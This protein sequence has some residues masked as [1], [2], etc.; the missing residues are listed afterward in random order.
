MK[1]R[2]QLRIAILCRHNLSHL[3][4]GDSV[5]TYDKT[6]ALAKQAAVILVTP[7]GYVSRDIHS[8]MRVVQVSPPGIR[9]ALALVPALLLHLRDYDC[10]YSR[11]P[12][13]IALAV[14]MKMFG[15][16][17]AIELNGIPSVETEIRRRTHKV[18]VPGLTSLICDFI[19]LIETFA[20]TSADLTI[21]VTERMRNTLLRDYGADVKKVT[22]VPNSVDTMLFK[23]LET[24]STAIRRKFGI[25]RETVVLYLSTFSARWRGVGQ[26]FHIADLVQRKRNDIVFLIVGSGPLLEEIEA[27]IPRGSTQ[28]RMVFA[29]AVEYRLVP[30][31]MSAADVYVYDVA[32]TTNKL[33]EKQGLC[34]AKILQAMSCGR[35]VIG[36]KVPDLEAILQNSGGGFC[37]SSIEEVGVL[38][39]RFADST[40][41]VKSMG[42]NA[43]RYVE[44]NH[45]LARLSK[46]KIELMTKAFCQK[47]H[48]LRLRA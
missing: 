48:P 36:P 39:E 7:R 18:R 31:Y 13:L 32:N 22:V 44:T 35:P 43:R 20:I 19:R 17:L 8:V 4:L 28:G 46:R 34:P 24:E 23:P 47:R 30:L 21:P 45:D 27:R 42:M 15:K 25:E 16:L 40:E 41:L 3:E 33:I 38:I 9:F 2:R 29:G 14:P 26:F 12:L 1:H 10:I 5:N 6:M 37:A 11:D